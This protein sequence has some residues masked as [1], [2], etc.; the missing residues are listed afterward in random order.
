[1]AKL[2]DALVLGTSTAMCE[3]SSPFPG[4][5]KELND[6]FGMVVAGEV[7]AT[8]RERKNTVGDD[9]VLKWTLRRDGIRRGAYDY[10]SHHHTLRACDIICFENECE[11]GTIETHMNTNLIVTKGHVALSKKALPVNL[12]EIKSSK[13]Q[14]IITK[15][16]IALADQE[17]GVAIAAPQIGES[18]Q[19]FV[20]SP[21]AYE[22][23]EKKSA[24]KDLIFI[25]PIIKKSSKEKEFLMEGCLS[26]RWLYG[27]VLRSKKVSLEYYNENGEKKSVGASGLLAQIFQHEFDHLQGILFD[28]KAKNLENLPPE[29]QKS[30]NKNL[31]K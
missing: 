23:K 16:Q 12:S 2:V 1:V 20:L 30:L 4:T 17:D 29:K 13:I 5:N 7:G 22:K 6:F 14:E 10:I 25:N 21:M 27:E 8:E 28:S 3:G 9:S 18:L 31:A 19:I 24:Q 11:L 26:V 15:M